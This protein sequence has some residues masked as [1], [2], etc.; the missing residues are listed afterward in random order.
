M[1]L[2][3]VLL[4]VAAVLAANPCFARNSHPQHGAQANTTN[5]AVNGTH[6]TGA[7]PAPANAPIDAETTVAPPVL[8]PRGI[9]QQQIRPINPSVKAV[10]PGNPSRGPTGA[11]TQKT[12]IVRNAIGQP[13]APAKNFAGAQ[14]TQPALQRPGS[15]SA[16]ILHGGSGAPP[17]VSSAARVN[18]ANTA[19]RGS[20][21]GATAIRPAA[22]PSGIGGPAQTRYGINGTAVQSKH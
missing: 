19:T 22:G 5:H 4:I 16:P 7:N 6:A 8:P 10:G 17:F 12:P 21:N 14:P 2:R 13:E 3:L 15:L 1:R 18:V 11:T 20:V 9:T